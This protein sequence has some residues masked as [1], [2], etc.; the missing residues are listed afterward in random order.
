MTVGIAIWDV[1]TE[2]YW[3]DEDGE[4]LI[5]TNEIAA[6]NFLYTEQYTYEFATTGVEYH[7]K[8]II[9]D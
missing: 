4:I 9:E 8:A 6:K 3:E 7:H 5:L 2:K 1:T